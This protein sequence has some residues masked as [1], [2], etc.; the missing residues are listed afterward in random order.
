MSAFTVQTRARRQM[1]NISREV[2]TRIQQSNVESGVAIVTVLHTTCALV[3]N[4]AGSGWE[5][6]MLA[7][8]EKIVPPMAFQHLHDGPEHAT[9][10]LLGALLGPTVQVAIAGGR[11]VLGTWQSI[12]MVELEGPR[13]R[14]IDVTVIGQPSTR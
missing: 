3:V 2:R 14:S 10:H 11:P 4:D 9:S 6:D 7:F 8:L 12:F 1:V 5:E 13:E